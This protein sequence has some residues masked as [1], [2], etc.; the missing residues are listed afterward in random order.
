MDSSIKEKANA[1]FD[2]L[3][4][5]MSAAVV[6]FLNQVIRSGGL[7]F[8]MTI[9]SYKAAARQESLDSLLSFASQNRRIESGYDFDREASHD[10]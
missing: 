7:P 9:E 10:R 4:L 5:S 6:I 1:I 3:G 2:E 8:E